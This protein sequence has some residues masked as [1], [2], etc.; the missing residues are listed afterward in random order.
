MDRRALVRRS[1]NEIQ[2]AYYT[3]L[4]SDAGQI[5]LDDLTIFSQQELPTGDGRARGRAD[6]VLRMLREKE[7][8][9]EP[10]M[11]VEET[12]Q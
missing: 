8:A 3:V 7:R 9:N 11:K 10:E 6:V 4:N 5:M 1:Y 12:D 2:K